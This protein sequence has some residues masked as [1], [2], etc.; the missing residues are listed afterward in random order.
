M[1]ATVTTMCFRCAEMGA[2]T[3]V[4]PDG[5]LSNPG[6]ATWAR[7]TKPRGRRLF[8]SAFSSSKRKKKGFGL[9]TA[10]R[11]R[12]AQVTFPHTE[13]GQS[14]GSSL[15]AIESTMSPNGGGKPHN[16]II[17]QGLGDESQYGLLCRLSVQ[18]SANL[19][20]S[21]ITRPNLD[22]DQRFRAKSCQFATYC[23][24]HFGI[25]VMTCSALLMFPLCEKNRAHP[26]RGRS[27]IAAAAWATSRMTC[28]WK[29]LIV[30]E[31]LLPKTPTT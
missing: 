22:H 19:A 5:R 31:N 20:K 25:T 30:S 1:M 23:A 28:G 8:S 13:G 2:R 7:P 6:C 4:Q 24:I 9:R 10:Q 15:N 16:A 18:C 26:Q 17:W 12:T 14:E 11:V 21:P 3:R 29:R 27:R